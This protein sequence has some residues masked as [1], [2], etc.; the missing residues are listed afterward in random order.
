MIGIPPIGLKSL[1]S[2]A[3]FNGHATVIRCDL[4][5]RGVSDRLAVKSMFVDRCGPSIKIIIWTIRANIPQLVTDVIFIT[6][7]KIC[8]A[9]MK[10]IA[11]NKRNRFN[12]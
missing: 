8:S 4:A 3:L 2:L 11:S 12:V 9:H 1:L 10:Y 7:D 6:K 5:A